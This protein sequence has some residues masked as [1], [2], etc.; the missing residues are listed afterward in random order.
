MTSTA[1]AAAPRKMSLV[2]MEGFIATFR[3]RLLL[4]D[5]KPAARCD[6]LLSAE[7]HDGFESVQRFITLLKPYE[8]KL[9]DMI[10]KGSTT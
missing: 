5:G 10:R 1:P 4:A 6:L 9:R 2:D 3:T 7:D 8:T